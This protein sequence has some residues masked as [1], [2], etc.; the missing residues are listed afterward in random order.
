MAPRRVGTLA[1]SI[2]SPLKHAETHYLKSTLL[3]ASSS[4]LLLGGTFTTD[5]ND[6]R[7]TV[8]TPTECRSAVPMRCCATLRHLHSLQE[9]SAC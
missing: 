2:G 4:T 1:A 5:Q 6:C 8:Y 9:R 7:R 3:S